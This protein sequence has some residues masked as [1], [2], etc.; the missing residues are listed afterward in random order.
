MQGNLH[1]VPNM[2]LTIDRTVVLPIGH[3]EVHNSTHHVV[4]G[5]GHAPI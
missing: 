2:L 5:P 1:Y 3:T 4:V